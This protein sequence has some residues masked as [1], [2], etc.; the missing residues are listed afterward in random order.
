MKNTI[1]A[2]VIFFILSLIILGNSIQITNTTHNGSLFGSI[3]I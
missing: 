1:K 3:S 2:I